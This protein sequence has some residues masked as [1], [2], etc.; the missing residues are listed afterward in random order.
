MKTLR[1]RQ[2][3]AAVSAAALIGISI[4]SAFAAPNYVP[5]ANSPL[6]AT[7]LDSESALLDA[8]NGYLDSIEATLPAGTT[9]R[10]PDLGGNLA[11]SDLQFYTAVAAAVAADSAHAYEIV[12]AAIQWRGSKAKDIVRNVVAITPAAAPDAVAAISN[13]VPKFAADAAAG[14]VLGLIIVAGTDSE[15]A[16]AADEAVIAKT[17]E[18][19]EKVA[20]SAISALKKSPTQNTTAFAVAE[21]IV[22]AMIVD[23]AGSNAELYFD[24][25]FR[26]IT[27]GA[28]NFAQTTQSAI[29]AAALSRFTG[30]A[31][32]T[33]HNLANAAVG[34]LK[35]TKILPGPNGYDDTAALLQTTAESVL[36][37]AGAVVAAGAKAEKAIRT[38]PSAT[39]DAAFSA[40]LT[41]AEAANEHILYGYVAGGVQA[42][43]GKAGS[44]VKLALEDA[45]VGALSLAQRQ[46][47]VAA[48]TTGNFGATSK[49]VLNGMTALANS[50]TAVE[51][52]QA[53]IP[54]SSDLFSGV[55]TNTAIKT[56]IKINAATTAVEKQAV[57]SAAIA[58]AV[59]SGYQRSLADIALGAAKADKKVDNELITTA[60]TEVPAGW[61]AAVAAAIVSNNAKES[62]RFGVPTLGSNEA[63]AIDAATAKGANVAAVSLAI[64]IA[65]SGKIQGKTLFEEA[66]EALYSPVG[67]ANPDAV[68]VGAGIVNKKFQI[69]LLAAALRL[70]TGAVTDAALLNYAI[71]LDKKKKINAELGFEAAIDAINAPNNIF[72]MVDHKVL[73]NPKNAVDIVSGVVGARP[74]FAHYA[75]RAASFRAAG[76]A[77]KIGAAAITYGH[78]RS[79]RDSLGAAVTPDDPSAVAAISA[80]VV[81][82]VLDAKLV[83]LKEVAAIKSAVA[84]MVKASLAF[85]N[86]HLLKTDPSFKAGLVGDS[87]SFPEAT[88]AGDDPLVAAN[89]VLR[90]S[91]GTA[92][93][94]T[95]AVA[96]TQGEGDTTLTDLSKVVITAAAKAAK[97][98]GLAIAQAAG[99]AAA[100]AA[101]F[102]GNVFADFAA[103]AAAFSGTG[104]AATPVQ[105][106][107]AARLGANQF[108]ANIFGAGAAGILNYAHH[109]GNTPPVT[110]LSN[111]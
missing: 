68:L 8:F 59:A 28:A 15:F 4:T 78:Q 53:A 10:K 55:A 32:A 102:G 92:G 30:T 17:R 107:N 33:F 13:A 29:A 73:S 89:F 9:L 12:A 96:Q 46:A 106:E 24:D 65:Q 60:V 1:N 27:G 69:P 77:G 44:F 34:A 7:T 51:A 54:A 20:K 39:E 42:L 25:A 56:A 62:S 104:V 41:A 2:F 88:G 66:I 43:K 47:V 45:D 98:H 26:G 57:L 21:A 82:G 58:S 19:I 64:D 91:K 79:N 5:P 23:A 63:A 52:V 100:A 80:A 105:L 74:E 103:I 49:A 70:N 71:S 35:G 87:D 111:F 72:D 22:D 48:A 97:L 83:T 14:A 11:P 85:A 40:N 75:A 61:E 37:G 3:A 90:R 110:D 31:A 108:A 99:A 81:L 6:D 101:S 94:V 93:A 67:S 86:P 18:L 16:D 38:A 76:S 84:S 109:S 36:A 95:G 50:L